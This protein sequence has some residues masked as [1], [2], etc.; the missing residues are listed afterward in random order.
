MN[1]KI[2]IDILNELRISSQT[3]LNYIV[4]LRVLPIFLISILVFF[5]EKTFYKEEEL[6]SFT[7]CK[8]NYIIK[9]IDFVLSYFNFTKIFRYYFHL[10][11]ISIVSI[12]AID[13]FYFYNYDGNIIHGA[14]RIQA[15]HFSLLATCEV[16]GKLLFQPVVSAFTDRFGFSYAFILF[17][18]LY[19]ICLINLM[20][21][22][23]ILKK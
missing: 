2:V 13:N 18:V 12:R 5:T 9:L 15:S 8:L 23:Q 17:T 22:P 21:K 20:F 16:F 11:T 6:N 4:I 10:S 14:K 7:L 3:W 1:F 19:L